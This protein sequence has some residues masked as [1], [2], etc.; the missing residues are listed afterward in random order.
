MVLDSVQEKVQVWVVASALEEALVRKMS[1][2]AR[3]WLLHSNRLLLR[4]CVRLTSPVDPS[5]TD[6]AAGPVV[7]L[8][9]ELVRLDGSAALLSRLRSSHCCS[10]SVRVSWG[11]L[12]STCS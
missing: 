1:T 7:L 2:P 9:Q 6:P 11:W 4:R 3:A 5:E 10:S 8:Q 12:A